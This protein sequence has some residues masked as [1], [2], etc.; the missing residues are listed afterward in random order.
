MSTNRISMVQ[1]LSS[2][3]IASLLGVSTADAQSIERI[4][5]SIST[6]AGLDAGRVSGVRMS[7]LKHCMSVNA[8]G[9]DARTLDSLMPL[10]RPG[11]GDATCVF[12]GKQKYA[13]DDAWMNFVGGLMQIIPPPA[14]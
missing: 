3:A 4:S 8:P 9:Y 2:I 6:T 1:T 12:P 5:H 14:D 7:G 10:Y 11:T 13:Y